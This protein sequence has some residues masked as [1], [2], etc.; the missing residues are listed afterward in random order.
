MIIDIDNP[1]GDVYV[2]VFATREDWL[3]KER[4]KNDGTIFEED[5]EAYLNQF[6]HSYPE[7]FDKWGNYGAPRM[8]IEGDII[9][10]QIK[11]RIKEI[12]L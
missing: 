3:N 1:D 7:D 8:I 5:A 10:P 2:R 9:V 4:E 11:E 6:V 12:G